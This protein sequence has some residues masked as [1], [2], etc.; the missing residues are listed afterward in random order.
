MAT[1]FFNAASISMGTLAVVFFVA[2]VFSLLLVFINWIIAK[3]ISNSRKSSPYECG[4]EPVGSPISDFEP[5]FTA[6][7][8]AFL[9]YD[10]EILLTYP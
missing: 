5:N 4:F 10:V 9:V 2:F 6:V 7:A 1:G 8:L 3:S